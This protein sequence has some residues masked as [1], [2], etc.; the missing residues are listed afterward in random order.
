MMTEQLEHLKAEEELVVS[1]GVS[2]GYSNVRT[3]TDAK[4]K[5][6]MRRLIGRAYPEV[7][8]QLR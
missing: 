5:S 7:R 1:M 2:Q 4:V 3:G 8:T 6:A